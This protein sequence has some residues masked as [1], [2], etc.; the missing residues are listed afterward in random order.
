MSPVTLVL[1]TLESVKLPFNSKHHQVS[2]QV[3]AITLS[4]KME[5]RTRH[6]K[7]PAHSAPTFRYIHG[8][9]ITANSMMGQ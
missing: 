2:S 6:T 3:E 5:S 4:N 8:L 1:Y 9:V 7:G